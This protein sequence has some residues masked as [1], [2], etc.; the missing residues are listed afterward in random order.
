MEFE[1]TK[2]Q[3]EIQKAAREFAKGEF[4][5]EL[6]TELSGK[7]E[8]PAA[9]CH[10]AAELGFIGMHYPE[11]CTGGGMGVLETVLTAEEFC[12]KDSTMGMAILFSGH[13]AEC[14]CRF[15]GKELIG[16]FVP[17][18]VEGKF[19]SAGAFFELGIGADLTAVKTT[20]VA[21]NGQWIINGRK[22]Y[23]PNGGSAGFYVV[24]CRTEPAAQ[25]AGNGLSLIV[26]EGDRD[27]I[28]AEDAGPTLGVALIPFAHVSFDDVRV[29]ETHLLAKTGAGF[30]QAHQF[31]NEL[32]IQLAG[33]ALGTAQGA[34]DRA[35]DYVRQREQFGKKLAQF[36]VLRHKIAE[37]AAEIES[38]R[39]LVYRTAWLFDK[40]KCEAQ[41]AATAKLV[42]C[43]AAMDVTDEA[44]QLL[45]GYGY[46]TEY[47]I[48]HFY[49]DAKTIEILMGAPASLKDAIADQLIGRL[50]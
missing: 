25:P 23:V 21:D 10:K 46:M 50:K 14:V 28:K 32:R 1:L 44:I 29:P 4:D 39:W 6:I 45:G 13:G 37:M 18:V 11:S 8:F 22:A 36:Q 47:E 24:L 30:G 41:N 7:R 26:V 9:I 35:L 38:V 42:A 5:K 16:K 48:E 19:R 27:G 33:I 2:P 12:R 31:V 43:R 3:K 49:R 40:K 34:F 20:A 17:P 15:G